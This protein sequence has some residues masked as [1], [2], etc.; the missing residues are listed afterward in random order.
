M[1]NG[2]YLMVLAPL[3]YPG[4]L[5]RGRYCY[6][7]HL[8]WWQNTG[9]TISYGQVIHHRNEDKHDNTIENL[10][11]IT[12]REHNKHHGK[13]N[14]LRSIKNINCLNCG[15][16]FV[17]KK[18]PVQIFCSRRCIGLYGHAKKKRL[19]CSSEV[20]QTVV[21]RKVAGPNPATPAKGKEAR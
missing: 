7:H 13:I 16:S 18:R 12:S 5:Y 6:E 17:Q 11:L 19:G 10:E 15:C 14:H 1:R 3:D 8:V 2:L 21:A 9:K 4:K 20:E